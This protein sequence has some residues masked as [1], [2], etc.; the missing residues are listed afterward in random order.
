MVRNNSC[1]VLKKVREKFTKNVG[2]K[3][4]VKLKRK[5]YKIARSTENNSNSKRKCR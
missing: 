5:I 3:F 4:W 1:K 2:N